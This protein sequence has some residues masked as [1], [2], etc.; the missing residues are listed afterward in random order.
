MSHEE[1]IKAMLQ[2][3]IPS[4]SIESEVQW[5]EAENAELLPMGIE[6]YGMANSYLEKILAMLENGGE[7]VMMAYYRLYGLIIKSDWFQV[8]D[9]GV[10]EGLR[11]TLANNSHK[12][13]RPVYTQIEAEL[14]KKCVMKALNLFPV[15]SELVISSRLFTASLAGYYD[16]QNLPIFLNGDRQLKSMLLNYTT[17]HLVKIKPA[18]EAEKQYYTGLMPTYLKAV[19]KNAKKEGILLYL[20]LYLLITALQGT[21]DGMLDAGKILNALETARNSSYEELQR[22]VENLGV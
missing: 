11:K 19:S 9:V 13:L 16:R 1:Y 20:L 12:N 4:L 17:L 3:Y 2:Y 10:A 14:N 15:N 5:E 7:D 22:N 6:E 18:T 8:D 21:N